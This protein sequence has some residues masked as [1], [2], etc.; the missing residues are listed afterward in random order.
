[1]FYYFYKDGGTI[2]WMEG[3]SFCGVH[4]LM[5]SFVNQFCVIVQAF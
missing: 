3:C 5:I 2:S 1:M 4:F